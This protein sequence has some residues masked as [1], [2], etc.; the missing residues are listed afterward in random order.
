MQGVRECRESGRQEMQEGE[1]RKACR[2]E[3]RE[4]GSWLRTNGDHTTGP[5]QKYYFLQDWGKKYA[6]ALLEDKSRLLGVPKRSLSQE[7]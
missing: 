6:L 1:G 3:G 2:Q 5:L 4:A 7:T